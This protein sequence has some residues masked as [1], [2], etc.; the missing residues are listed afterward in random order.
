MKDYIKLSDD[1]KKIILQSGET[2]SFDYPVNDFLVFQ[3]VTVVILDVPVQKKFNENVFAIS[4]NGNIL[5]QIEKRQFVYENSP[6]TGIESSGNNVILYNWDGLK[7]TV[8][9]E[10]GE[11]ISQ[12]FEK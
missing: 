9:P 6:Y 10:T 2:V 5:W 7:L 11:I 4:D 12:V 3:K 1:R 8:V